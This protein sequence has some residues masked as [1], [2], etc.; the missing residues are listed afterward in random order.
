MDL[1]KTIEALETSGVPVLGYR[2][3][4]FPAFYRRESGLRVDLRCDAVEQLAK[5]VA[6]HLA[7]DLNPTG[8]LV[9][10]PIPLES[11]MRKEVYD[12]ALARTFEA[13]A[14]DPVRGRELTPFLL[15]RLD[16][17]TGGVSVSANRALLENNARLAAQLASALIQ[18]E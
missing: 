14:R 4:E 7:L 12:G 18:S 1:P 2:T 5:V 3:D 17:F 11:E 13:L 16:Q 9:A 6:T 15:E 8:L 10:N